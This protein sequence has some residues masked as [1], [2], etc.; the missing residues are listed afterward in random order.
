MDSLL[1]SGAPPAPTGPLADA[2]CLAEKSS[3]QLRTSVAVTASTRRS[4]KADRMCRR[5]PSACER[6]VAGFQRSA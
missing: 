3:N 4:P 1:R 6:R 2:A 5:M